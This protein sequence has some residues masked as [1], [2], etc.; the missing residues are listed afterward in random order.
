ML[1]AWKAMKDHRSPLFWFHVTERPERQMQKGQPDPEQ[2]PGQVPHLIQ[3]N[4]EPEVDVVPL[5]LAKPKI[6]AL[7]PLEQVTNQVKKTFAFL[8][9]DH[10]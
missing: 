3:Q 1:D 5:S 7:A 4:L 6:H 8:A 2:Y 10:D 9:V